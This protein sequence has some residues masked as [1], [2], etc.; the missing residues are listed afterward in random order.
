MFECKRNATVGR[1]VVCPSVIRRSCTKQLN[2]VSRNANRSGTVVYNAT[3]SSNAGAV[4]NNIVFD[5]SKSLQLSNNIVFIRRCSQRSQR[6][7]GGRTPVLST[8]LTV[9]QTDG[10]TSYRCITP[11]SLPSRLQCVDHLS[12]LFWP[13]LVR[14]SPSHYAPLAVSPHFV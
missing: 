10:R 9:D 3:R 2:E 11:T 4:G 6:S 12:R 7:D 13:Y 5:R 1:P 8:T 14:Q